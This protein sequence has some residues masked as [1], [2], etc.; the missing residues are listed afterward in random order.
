[1]FPSHYLG[2]E[3]R[4]GELSMIKGGYNGRKIGIM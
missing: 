1:V 2:T 4:E 3:N